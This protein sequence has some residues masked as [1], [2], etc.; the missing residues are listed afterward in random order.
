MKAFLWIIICSALYQQTLATHV[1]GG[2]ISYEYLGGTQYR[3][4][5]KVYRDCGPTNVNGTGFDENAS[6]GIY[7]SGNGALYDG[8]YSLSL[9]S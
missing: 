1:V 6:I 8:N 4:T 3:I 2:E 5:L 7:L 9:S